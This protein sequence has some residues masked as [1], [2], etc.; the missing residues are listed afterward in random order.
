MIA[1][2]YERSKGRFVGINRTESCIR[3]RSASGV[4]RTW[5]AGGQTSQFDPKLTFVSPRSCHLSD[6]DPATTKGS[7]SDIS[8]T[9]QYF[10]AET[11]TRGAH[12][13]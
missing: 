5:R 1:S 8:E 9:L 11:A 4:E 2:R 7:I 3:M 6:P 10:G 13:P 12:S